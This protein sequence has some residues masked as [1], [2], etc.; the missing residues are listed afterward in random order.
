MIKP[1]ELALIKGYTVTKEG[2]LLNR[3]GIQVKGRIK[4][5]KRDYYNFD[6][7]IGPRKENKKV[8]LGDSTNLSNKML[9]VMAIIEAEKGKQGDIFVNGDLNNKFQPYFREKV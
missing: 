1:E 2:I 4:D 5:R 7:R 9:Y 6:I 3:N 8:H